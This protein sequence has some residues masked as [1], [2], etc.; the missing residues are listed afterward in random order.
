M[1]TAG[2][3][4]SESIRRVAGIEEAVTFCAEWERRRDELQFAIDG[5]VIKV[6]D[7]ALQRQLGTVGREPRSATTYQFPAEQAVT[8]L[9]DIQVSVGRTGVLTP[10][11]VLEPVWV[12]GATVGVATLHNEEQVRLKD[13]RIGDDVIVQRA[14]DVIPEVV[15]PVRSRREGREVR[16]FVM[17]STCPACGTAVFRDP[18]AVATYCPN[19]RC[20]TKLARQLEH[21][22]SR[23]AMDIEGLG[24]QLSWRLVS[25]G[26]VATVADVFRL[27]ERRG[28]AGARQDRREDAR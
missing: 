4:V 13:V 23:G 22:A 15:G 5:V 26:F 6:D 10:F 27:H 3:R 28:S 17:P 25:L 2:F 7:F 8:L 9:R 19:R 21:F 12:G 24:E 1:R 20:P 11:A 16:E 14:G 18:E